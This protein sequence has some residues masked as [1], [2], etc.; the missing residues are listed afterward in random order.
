MSDFAE[1]M[2]VIQ[3]EAQARED[4]LVL[5]QKQREKEEVAR[6]LKCIEEAHAQGKR[7][8]EYRNNISDAA[9]NIVKTRCTVTPLMG[10]NPSTHDDRVVGWTLKW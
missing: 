6:I 1:R 5:A 4:C 3:R 9:M 2:T 7:S 10:C 8:C